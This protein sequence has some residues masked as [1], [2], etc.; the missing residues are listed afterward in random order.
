LLIFKEPTN[1]NESE[2][3]VNKGKMGPPQDLSE[4][5]DLYRKNQQAR[6]YIMKIWVVEFSNGGQSYTYQVL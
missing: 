1:Q 4:D 6:L 3:V 5:F 2:Q